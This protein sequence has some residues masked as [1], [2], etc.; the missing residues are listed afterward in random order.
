MAIILENVRYAIH[1]RYVFGDLRIKIK[2]VFTTENT[3]VAPRSEKNGELELKNGGNL[4]PAK[5][6]TRID[7]EKDMPLTPSTII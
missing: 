4:R 5:N 1:V 3:T 2:L 7:V 6:T